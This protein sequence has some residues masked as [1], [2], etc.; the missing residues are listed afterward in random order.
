MRCETSDLG[1]FLSPFV[2]PPDLFMFQTTLRLVLRCFEWHAH[3]AQILFLPEAADYIALNARASLEL[4]SPQKSSLF[5][6][7]LQDAAKRHGIAVHVGIHHR[8]E[9]DGK[10]LNRNLYITSEGVID[11]AATYDKLHVFDYGALKESATVQPGAALTPPFDSPVGRIGSLICFDLRFPEAAL[12]LSQPSPGSAWAQ[13]PAQILTYPSAFTLRTGVAHWETLLRARAI[14]TQSWV[15][16]AAQVGWHNGNRAS[17]GRSLVVDPWGRVVLRLR[18]AVGYTGDAEADAEAI[19][20]G[21]PE[22][23]AEEGGVE[24][25]GFVDVDLELWARVRKE[26]PLKRRTDVYPE[27][28]AV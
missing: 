4:A 11:D 7:G 22:G 15:V 3:T 10:L 26:M 23:A 25:L 14:E 20:K 12:A 27:L 9:V 24:E 2:S 17:F 21:I 13:R 28:T 8:P 1:P 6:T 19:S 5:V 18:G 16:A